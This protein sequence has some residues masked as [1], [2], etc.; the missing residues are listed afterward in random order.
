MKN[1][2]IFLIGVAIIAILLSAC[3][4]A[5][6]PTATARVIVV[7]ATFPPPTDTPYPSPT[8]EPPFTPTQELSTNGS[9][10]EEHP[11]WVY[12]TGNGFGLWLPDS[13]VVG[14][15]PATYIEM[16]RSL[17]EAG[18]D[19]VA[20]LLEANAS[21]VLLYAFDTTINNPDNYT[22]NCNVVAEW[23]ALIK[24]MTIDDYTNIVISQYSNIQGIRVLE[25]DPWLTTNFGIGKKI[26]VE[27]DLAVLAGVPGTSVGVQYLMKNDDH[28]WAL[29]CATSWDEYDA[30]GPDFEDFAL[31][32]DESLD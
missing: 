1:K 8:P 14:S 7:T 16:A 30:R 9:I 27:Y 22:T 24:D 20:S 19:Q 12:H 4:Q 2:L 29:S 3:A 5:A 21:Y 17:R 6:Q 10:L 11:D 31:G 26:V 25:T 32:F 23:N 13:Y 15:D 28:I 18:Q